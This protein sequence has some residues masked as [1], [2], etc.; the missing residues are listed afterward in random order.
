MRFYSPAALS[1]RFQ[2]TP[3]AV[4]RMLL[5][6]PIRCVRIAGV[7]HVLDVDFLQAIARISTALEH[8][9]GGRAGYHPDSPSSVSGFAAINRLVPSFSTTLITRATD[10]V[11]FKL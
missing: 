5:E 11:Q 8:T 1:R 9:D 10:R 2:L 4:R 6:T 3:F 7:L